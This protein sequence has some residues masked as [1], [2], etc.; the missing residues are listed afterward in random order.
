MNEINS[1]LKWYSA[2]WKQRFKDQHLQEFPGPGSWGVD[3]YYLGSCD[4]LAPDAISAKEIMETDILS[5]AADYNLVISDLQVGYR[6][7]FGQY[8]M[9]QAQLEDTVDR[10][11]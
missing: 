6:G 11:T 2:T 3:D 9:H 10:Q 8:Q 5:D 4:L 1:G 7:T